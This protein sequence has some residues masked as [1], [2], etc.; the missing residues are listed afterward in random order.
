MASN[1]I[2]GFS[3]GYCDKRDVVSYLVT[4][5]KKL[6]VTI[7]EQIFDEIP[8]SFSISYRKLQSIIVCCNYEVSDII[9]QLKIDIYQT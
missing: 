2:T 6:N 9:K 4:L 3:F 8:E 1:N 5:Y 7:D